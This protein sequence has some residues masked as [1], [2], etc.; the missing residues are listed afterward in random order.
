[1]CLDEVII[2]QMRIAAT[3]P[4][5]FFSLAAAQGFVSVQT[6]NSLQQTLTAQD[7]VNSWDAARKAMSRVKDGCVSVG[8][9]NVQLQ[10]FRR[11]GAPFLNRVMAPAKQLHCFERPDRPLPKQPTNNSALGS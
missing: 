5:D 6:P 1:M 10:Q 7:L 2:S 11:N 3:N 8:Q 9:L 4:G